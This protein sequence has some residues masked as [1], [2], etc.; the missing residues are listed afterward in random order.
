MFS[1]SLRQLTC[2]FDHALILGKHVV[3]KAYA[4]SCTELSVSKSI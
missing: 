3:D 4:L 1:S 2:D